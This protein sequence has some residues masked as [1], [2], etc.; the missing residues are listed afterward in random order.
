MFMFK[1]STQLTGRLQPRVWAASV[2]LLAVLFHV[3]ATAAKLSLNFKGAD[4]NAVIQAVADVT[5]KNF[6]VDPRVKG[7]VTIISKRALNE[8]EVYEV[9]LSVLDVHGY[10]AIPS[11][12]VIK[13]I[14]DADGKHS[15]MPSANE[16]NPGKGDEAVTRVIEIDHVNAAQLV[17]I[18]RPLVPP[19]GHLAAYP[20]SNVLIISD[21]ARNIERIV[22][23]IKRIDQPTSGEI[24]IIQLEHA[25]AADLVRVLTSLQQKATKGAAKTDE[26]TFV[27][28]ERTNSILIGGDKSARLQLRAIISHLDTPSEVVGDTHVVYLRYANAKDMVPVLT[29]VGD[30]QKK[31]GIAGK[32]GAKGA[33]A[34]VASRPSG[35]GQ[36]LLNIQADETANALVITAPP[37]LFRSLEAVIRQLDVRRAQVM[38]EAIIAEVS[39]DKAAEM[40]IEWFFDGSNSDR[41]VGTINASSSGVGSVVAYNESG[42]AQDAAGLLGSGATLAFGRFNSNTF[43]FAGVIKALRSTGDT[44]IL[45][46]PS[47]VT[48]DNQEAEIFIGEEVSIPTGSFT[49]TGGGTAPANPFTTYERVPIGISLKV[50]PQINEGDAILLEINQSVDSIKQ[51]AAGQGDVVTVERKINT[52]VMVDNGKMLVLGGLVKD[53]VVEAH[54]QVPILGDIP[55]LGALFRHSSVKKLKTNLMVF[56]R[57]VILRDE[58]QGTILTNSKYTYMRNL[59]LQAGEE[60]PIL[61]EESRPILPEFDVMMELP[62]SFHSLNPDAKPLFEGKTLQPPPQSRAVQT[63]APAS[64]LPP[65]PTADENF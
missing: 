26:P 57:P 53:D 5:G 43:N 20:Q 59:Q 60:L 14:P 63:P 48:M 29:G 37:A 52:S 1:R 62:P 9:F 10:T 34:P 41:P 3:P 31:A 35:S 47:I 38:V 46:T 40:G 51:G 61:A 30:T 32:P 7:K 8:R 55:I 64:E 25:A 19:Q 13:I 11:G 28:D 44:N 4:I 50:K 21:R 22:K 16:K 23:I 42:R 36:P 49:N 15:G 2:L 18:L 56:L 12:R 33:P 65:P 27:A 17:P 39:V 54:Q 45:S 24:E 6:I 58:R